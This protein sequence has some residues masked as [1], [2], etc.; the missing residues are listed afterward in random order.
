MVFV[1][2]LAGVGYG[3][4]GPSPGGEIDRVAEAVKGVGS[5]DRDRLQPTAR[6]EAEADRDWFAFVS[7]EDLAN[8]A[9]FVP[10]G[11]LFPLVLPALRRW[12]VPAGVALSS[13]IELLQLTLLTH[14]SPTWDDIWWNGIGTVIGFAA[15]LVAFGL[16]LP[17]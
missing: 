15:F 1:V 2:F 5:R 13:F 3:T 6:L 14:R 17:K 16:K 11:V 7:A 8:V 12:T 9:M 4:F 10:F